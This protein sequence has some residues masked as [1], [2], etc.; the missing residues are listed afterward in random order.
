MPDD[1]LE[2]NKHIVRR[3]LEAFNTGDTA[4]VA[5]LIDR[6]IRDHGRKLGLE[7]EMRRADPIR[8][9]RTEILRQE[10]VFPD[11]QFKEVVLVAEGDTVVLVWSMTGTN[12]GSILGHP[13]TGKRVETQGIEIVRI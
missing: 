9:L 7:L 6:N 13:P 11:R 10:D 4:I 1:T 3:M 2:K 5:E 8:R 12:L